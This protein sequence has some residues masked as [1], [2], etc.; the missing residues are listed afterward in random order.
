MRSRLSGGDVL[1][2]ARD[3]ETVWSIYDAATIRPSC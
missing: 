1:R 3:A 2:V